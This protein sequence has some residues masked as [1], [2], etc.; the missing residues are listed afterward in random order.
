MS[1]R[2]G[3]ASVGIGPGILTAGV[4]V[5]PY[6]VRCPVRRLCAVRPFG[7]LRFA[8]RLV[9]SAARAGRCLASRLM[10]STYPVN[11]LPCKV[12]CNPITALGGLHRSYRMA[13][14]WPMV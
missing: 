7:R 2:T 8:L 9:S 3:R 6:R 11:T 13:T 5:R 14:L 10:A 4:S 12:R 1:P